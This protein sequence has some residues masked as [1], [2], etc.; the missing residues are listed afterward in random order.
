MKL[1]NFQTLDGKDLYI[2][3]TGNLIPVTKSGQQLKFTFRA[4]R[5]NRLAFHVKVKDAQLDPVARMMFM[6]DPKVAKG[7]PAQQPVCVLNI[8]LPEVTF[9]DKNKG[10]K[11]IT[12]LIF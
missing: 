12:L 9:K 11:F 6:R 1:K 5:Q 2:E 3:F 8:V 4:F 7:E 10:K